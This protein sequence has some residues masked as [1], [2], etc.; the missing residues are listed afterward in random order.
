MI[1]DLTG[2]S[3]GSHKV[4]SRDRDEPFITNSFHHQMC[5]PHKDTHILAWSH[6][7]LSKQ[8]IGDK[9]EVIEYKGP[10]VEAIYH[11][12]DKVIGVQWHPEA[13]PDSGD[14][15]AGTS[16]FRHLVKDHMDS[17]G[18]KFKRLY[19]GMEGA[20]VTVSEAH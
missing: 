9:D 5:I 2:H 15:V 11:P 14:W 20:Q 19:L 8:Y 18:L 6:Q 7:K 1:H 13:T 17:E 16:W 10:E 4:M 12:W 3:G